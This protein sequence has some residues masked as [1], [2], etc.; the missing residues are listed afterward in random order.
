[1]TTEQETELINKVEDIRSSLFYIA[2]YVFI[3][4]FVIILAMASV[5]DQIDNQNQ[6]TMIQAEQITD[7]KA[8]MYKLENKQR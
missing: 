6:Q 2:G 4:V 7:L 8:R 1:M 5:K 3:G